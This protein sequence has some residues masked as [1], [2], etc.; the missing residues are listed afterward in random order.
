MELRWP[1]ERV[2]LVVLPPGETDRKKSSDDGK[3]TMTFH[4]KEKKVIS[5]H[6]TYKSV[7]SWSIS[8]M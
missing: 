5:L 1:I 2:A 4:R 8:F 6:C 7:R 3:S